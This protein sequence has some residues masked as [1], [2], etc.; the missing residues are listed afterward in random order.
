MRVLV[1]PQEFKGSLTASAAARAIASG[2]R[3]A[4]PL[5]EIDVLPLSDGGPG[6]IDALHA[7]L[8]GKLR[9]TLVRDPLRRPALA[10]VLHVGET[11]YVEAAEANGLWRVAPDERKPWLLTSEGVGHLVGFA[12]APGT[13]RIV[14]GIGGSATNDAGVGMAYAL[15]AAFHAGSRA[16]LP[17]P[18]TFTLIDHVEWKLPDSLTS[19]SIVVASDVRN[20]LLGPDGATYVYGPQKGVAEAE[21]A[22]L[23]DAVGRVAAVIERDLGVEA[24]NRPGAGA[25]G[26]LGFGLMA[27]LDASVRPG[28]DIVAEATGLM[29]RLAA[30]DR[31]VTGEGRYDAQ[32]VFGKV[33]GRVQEAG[34]SA[35]IPVDILAGA[36]QT[37]GEPSVHSLVSF[38]GSEEAA[39][40]EAASLLEGLAASV[41][42]RW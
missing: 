11:A 23:D 42:S 4:R 10:H 12:G 30:T 21:L 31:I 3:R 18:E 7:A 14:V 8:G 17:L 38:A 2:I 40:R 36:S 27:F 19:K 32:S 34:A 35:G 20:P 37:E 5:A 6:F 1:C 9:A 39:M 22:A 33:T 29:A 13:S 16:V 28:F 24:A 41:A 15:G 26:G 25:A